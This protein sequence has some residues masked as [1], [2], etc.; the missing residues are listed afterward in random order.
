VFTEGEGVASHV[1]K[2]RRGILGEISPELAKQVRAFL[3]S[4]LS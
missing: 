3:K 1:P 2:A 4:Q